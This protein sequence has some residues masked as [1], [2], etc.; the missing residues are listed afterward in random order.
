MAHRDV[1]AERSPEF[2]PD[3]FNYCDRWCARCPFSERCA[4]YAMLREA[5]DDPDH[6]RD[7]L[8]REMKI[9]K[10]SLETA[11]KELQQAREE[12]GRSAMPATPRVEGERDRL[13][14]DAD[15]LARAAREYLALCAGWTHAE[16]G[17][18]RARIRSVRAAYDGPE[19]A[20]RA[21]VELDEHL[22]VIEHDATLI[23]TKTYRAVSGVMPGGDPA[24][25]GDPGRTARGGA[26]L[27]QTDANGSA[28]V[29]LLALD[30]AIEAWQ[31]V[32]R[33][34]AG[35]RETV[36]VMCEWLER[37]RAD[38]EARFPLARRF[39]RPGFDG[40]RGAAGDEPSV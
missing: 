4:A 32:A 5:G 6:P 23:A 11:S 33:F 14:V 25:T 35:G 28:K 2:V 9:V 38:V 1:S 21:L 10:W 17:A 36:A 31:G 34:H 12:S 37:L 30:R 18:L 20:L 3:I 8:D 13:A 29:V 16:G 26:G 19:A 39:R 27:V 22:T 24:I 40:C 7:G 15:P